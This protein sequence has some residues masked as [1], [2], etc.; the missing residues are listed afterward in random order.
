VVTPGGKISKLAESQ[1]QPAQALYATLDRTL[2]IAAQ[3]ALG[4]F[5]GSIVILNPATGEV[6]AMVSNPTFDPNLFELTAGDQ[7]ALA[8]VLN[9]PG[10]P[11]LNRAAQSQYPPG[12]VFKIPV[13][14]AALLSGLYHRDTPYTCT[15]VWNLLG[16]TAI[17]YDWTVTFGAKPHGKIDLV[18]ALPFSCDTYFYTI[19][20][21]LQNYNPKFIPQVA[22]QFGLGRPTQI[23]QIPEASGLIPDPDWKLTTVGE[24][25]L[26]GDSVNM[27]IGQGFVQVTPLQIAEMMAAVR[28]GGALYRPQLIHHIAPPIGTPT[29]QF[30]PIADGR[31]PV[32][33]EQLALIQEGLR[34]VTTL[35]GGTAR[36][37][38]LNIE[39]PV[40]G[41]TGTAED[42]G[43]GGEPHAWFA[44]YTEANRT[45]KPDI[46]MVVMVENQGEGSDFAAPIFRRLVEIYF[47]GKAY[48]LYPWESDFNVAATPTPAP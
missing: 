33:A 32:T 5:R 15:G 38:F 39:I 24:P 47:L 10:K 4:R 17:K 40:A 1:A 8:E 35:P 14:A 12:S 41:K 6:L 29:Y 13:M 45:D 30:T 19:A 7:A 21:D 46:A 18:Q 31:L 28:N 16:P 26:P 23:G 20:L 42:P 11:L 3:E 27:G 25:W 34:G 44:G 37:R 48:T 43:S 9:D 36:H 2:Q 22:R